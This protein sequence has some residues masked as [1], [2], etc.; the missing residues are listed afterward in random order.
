MTAS[1]RCVRNMSRAHGIS[2]FGRQAKIYMM[3]QSRTMTKEPQRMRARKEI[4]GKTEREIEKR[5]SKN[6]VS[7]KNGGVKGWEAT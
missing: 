1:S 7:N 2:C 3:Y 5:G 6:I 4:E